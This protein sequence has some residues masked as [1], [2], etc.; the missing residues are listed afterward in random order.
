MADSEETSIEINDSILKSVR[1]LLGMNE[2][3]TA[4]DNDLI[5]NINSVFVILNQLGVGP[6]DV[7]A[8][9]GEEE[10]WSDFLEDD[11]TNMNF[12]KSYMH[13][14][15]KSWFDPST[16]VA[17]IESNERVISELEF[18]MMVQADT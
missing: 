12:V 4:F 14:K 9:T 17:A 5:I 18:R 10:L 15:I 16:S 1:K 3:Y 7:F 8:I 6:D 11:E 2:S 13:Q